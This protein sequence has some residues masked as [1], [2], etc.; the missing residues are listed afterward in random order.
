MA[1]GVE[2]RVPFLDREF[3]EYAMEIQPNEK[4]CGDRIEKYILR[5]AFDDEKDP[6]LLLLKES[7]VI[8]TS[9]PHLNA[10]I[11]SVP[12]HLFA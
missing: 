3:L 4:M 9:R 7:I 5:K 11:A 12:L 2:A 6:Y 8:N 1:W 10:N